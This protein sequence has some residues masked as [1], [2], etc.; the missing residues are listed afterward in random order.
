MD[1]TVEKSNLPFVPSLV[2]E[3][4]VEPMD[5]KD[6]LVVEDIKDKKETNGKAM[7][8]AAEVSENAEEKSTERIQ[9]LGH[10]ERHSG[11]VESAKTPEKC[12]SPSKQLDTE[13]TAGLDEK[14]DKE[15]EKS[16]CEESVSV[17]NNEA[18]NESENGDLCKVKDA[19]SVECINIALDDDDKDIEA[20]QDNGKTPKVSIQPQIDISRYSPAKVMR[21][22]NSNWKSSAVILK[23]RSIKWYVYRKIYQTELLLTCS[24]CKR[25]PHTFNAKKCLKNCE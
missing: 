5:E 12:E 16:D 2:G 1:A 14:S 15:S 13:D 11:A 3:K 8:N 19:E 24:V 9:G 23:K 4:N 22:R 20:V 6:V 18:V 10:E 25:A 21:I 17:I 7:R